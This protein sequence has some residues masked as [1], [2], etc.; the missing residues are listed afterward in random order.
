MN[1]LKRLWSAYYYKFHF[2][3]KLFLHIA[4]NYTRSQIVTIEAMLKEI[5]ESRDW[6]VYLKEDR[7]YVYTGDKKPLVIRCNEDVFEGVG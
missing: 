6:R 7:L 2:G 3:D 4:M 5:H 1:N